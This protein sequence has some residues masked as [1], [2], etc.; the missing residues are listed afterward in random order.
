M[1]N[2]RATP[3]PTNVRE[4][5]IAAAAVRGLLNSRL[6]GPNQLFFFGAGS[7]VGD[8]T[9]SETASDHNGVK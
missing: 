7:L 9:N 4:N 2:R 3:A 5:E 8:M 1:P 6:R